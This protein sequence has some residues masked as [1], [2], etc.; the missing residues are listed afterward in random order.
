[1]V[2]LLFEPFFEDFHRFVDL[3]EGAV[4]QRQKSSGLPVLRPEQDHFAEARDRLLRPL[5]PVQE[6]AEVGVRINVI[7]IQANGCSIGVFGFDRVTR[8]AQQYA[9]I[10]VCIGVIRIERNGPLVGIDGLVEPALRL[11]D[12]AQVAITVGPVG[13]QLQTL[14]DE[15]DRLVTPP[16]LMRKHT[17]IVQGVMVVGGNLKNSA[18]DLL[19]LREL[20]ILLQED[21]DRNRLLESQF[22]RR[23]F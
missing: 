1:M 7:G 18:I 11:Q 16:L 3:A 14:F 12:D 22:A 4:R 9:E 10:A 17:G 2:W 19:R 8:R 5:Q 13:P 23:R 6:D 20:L 21:G 15:R